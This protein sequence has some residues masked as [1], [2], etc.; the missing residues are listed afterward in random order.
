MKIK[1]LFLVLALSFPLMGCNK[2]IDSMFFDRDYFAEPEWPGN[3]EGLL[4]VRSSGNAGTLVEEK[5]QNVYGNLRTTGADGDVW[6]SQLTFPSFPMDAGGNKTMT[7][8]TIEYFKSKPIDV[9]FYSQQYH[10]AYVTWNGKEYKIK[11]LTGSYQEWADKG[12]RRLLITIL[13]D[14]PRIIIDY[15]GRAPLLEDEEED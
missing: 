12:F 7:H 4:I 14:D 3:Y 13:L 11:T 15:D 8:L 1:H 10:P 9:N 6:D 5:F 2:M